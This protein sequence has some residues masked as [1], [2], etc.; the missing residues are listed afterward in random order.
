MGCENNFPLLNDFMEK[1]S[2]NIPTPS[3][4]MSPISPFVDCNSFMNSFNY[5]QWCMSNFSGQNNF[6]Q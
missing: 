4:F 2:S 3:T 6:G 1:G 5:F